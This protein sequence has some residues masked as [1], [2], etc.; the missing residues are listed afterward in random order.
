VDAGYDAQGEAAVEAASDGE[1]DGAANETAAPEP[2]RIASPGA[3]SIGEDQTL[4]LQVGLESLPTPD[5]RIAVSGLPP[6]A[7]WSEPE[8][9][10]VFTPDFIQ[11]G[12]SWDVTLTARNGAGTDTETFTLTVNDTIHPP[13]PT[14]VKTEQGSGYKSLW[15]SQKTDDYLDSP[16]HAGRTFS[17]RVIVPD[18]ASASKPMPVRAY[19]HGFGG[20]PYDGV[21]SGGQF[22]IYP[23]DSMNS[24][25]WGY[26]SSLP[27]GAPAGQVPNYTQRRV[28]H[29]LEWVLREQQGAD[30]ERV[31]V[32][33]GSMGGAGAATLAL[34]YAR[35]F[36]YADATIGQ[37]I[38]RNHRPARVGQL[39]GL[40]G[41][42][43]AN[44]P[45]GTMLED[46]RAAGVWDRQDLCR[47]LREWPESRRVHLFT[48]HGK[49]DPTIHFGAMTLA[50]PVTKRSF[51]EALRDHGVGH[52]VV[53]DEGGHGSADPVMPAGWWDGDWS[54]SFDPKAWLRRNV[55]FPAFTNASHDWDPGDGAGNGK[56]PWSD[57]SGY[58][59]TV[60]V[61]GDTGWNG[62]LAGARNRF[63]RWDSNAVV[64]EPGE[65]RIPLYVLDGIG[66][67]APKVGYPGLGDKFDRT[68]PVKVDV[69]IRRAQAFACKPGE[70][71]AWSFGAAKG[72]T[73]AGEDGAVTIAGLPLGLEPV[74]LVLTR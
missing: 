5:L 70:T 15:L 14:V 59:G 39:A 55:A 50:S 3:Q 20:G 25:W 18:G 33:G 53:W 30:P 68:L 21:S 28:L 26:A 12:R 46:G 58:A 49:D 43:A 31:Y 52:Y 42:P 13:W 63:L 45:D 8:R 69:T 60:S 66:S 65:F 47:V 51:L 34:L 19:L 71:I 61:A 35:H 40:W 36:A 7:S 67:P 56:Q 17:A 48:K 38:P 4:S 9:R 27:G 64:D 23:H 1:Q 72:T 74:T 73:A 6:G 22:R 41:S 10:I 24:Y 11:G 32:T 16:G 37:M 57:D 62:Q 54:R 29:L 2:P 44:L